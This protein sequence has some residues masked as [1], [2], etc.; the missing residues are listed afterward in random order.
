M[1]SLT[2]EELA[3]QQARIRRAAFRGIAICI[4][5]LLAARVG[6]PHIWSFPAG[7][8]ERIAFV[9]QASVFVWVWVLFGVRLVAKGRYRSAADNRGSA[10]GPPS[11]VIAIPVAFLQNS[12]E[13]AVLAVGA[14]LALATL[15]PPSDLS[16]IIGG[17]VLFGVGRIAFLRGYASGAGGRALG[18]VLTVIPTL[19]AYAY[20]VGLMAL[21]SIGM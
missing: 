4:V 15:A 21:R 8:V 5:V 11:P 14:Y 10:F 3:I 13:Q 2:P 18:I 7:A 20:A 19:A 1:T 17:V 12:L 6:L 9:L 16:L